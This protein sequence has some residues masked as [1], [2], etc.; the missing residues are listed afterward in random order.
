MPD[1]FRVRRCTE[2]APD[3]HGADIEVFVFDTTAD[4]AAAVRS[5]LG[6]LGDEEM[7]GGAGLLAG[8]REVRAVMRALCRSYTQARADLDRVRRAGRVD[9]VLV[10]GSPHAHCLTLLPAYLGAPFAAVGDYIEPHDSSAPLPAASHPAPLSGLAGNMAFLQRLSNFLH[11]AV[12]AWSGDLWGGF[13][14]GTA[15]GAR[16]S[17]L[18]QHALIRKAAL[19]LENSDHIVDYPKASFPNFVQVGGLTAGP[20]RPL[21]GPLGKFF[22]GAPPGG[23]GGGAGGV[24]VVSLGPHVFTPNRNLEEKLLAAFRQLPEWRVL[25][26]LNVSR[27]ALRGLSHVQTV[28]WF[29]QNDALGH[30]RTRLFVS[31]CGRN[32]FFEALH[33]AVPLLCCHFGGSDALGTGARVA[34]HGVGLTL[35]LLTATPDSLAAAVTAL[36]TDGSYARRAQAASRLFH[37]RPEGPAQRAARA[38]EHVLKY[39]GGYLRPRVLDLGFLQYSGLDV[40]WTL[41]SGVLAAT[42]ALGLGLRRRWWPGPG[43]SEGGDKAKKKEEAAR[44]PAAADPASPGTESAAAGKVLTRGPEANNVSLS[45]RIAACVMLVLLVLFYIVF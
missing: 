25:L 10:D 11:Y 21:P 19:Y 41:F 37:S 18:D 45:T 44:A 29:P 8:S 4:V 30:P 33:H 42:A 1:Y 5:Q 2:P 23:A 20:A 32:S 15:L 31:L 17:R 12:R 13:H 6:R 7:G 39:G 14:Q 24:V 35:D 38:V 26:R 28:G 16:V 9:F 36:L 3:P 27:R 40:A 43:P 22:D 34:E